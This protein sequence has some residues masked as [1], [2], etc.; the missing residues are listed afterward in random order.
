ML[1]KTE[2]IRRALEELGDAPIE[3]LAVFARSRYGVA[4]PLNIIPVI[5]T[6]LRNREM[7]EGARQPRTAA[8][9]CGPPDR[10]GQAAA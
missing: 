6:T 5:R 7:L 8:P 10:P 4:V 9:R 3:Q 1:D 2:A